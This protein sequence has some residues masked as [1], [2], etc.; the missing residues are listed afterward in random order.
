MKI[1]HNPARNVRII[2]RTAPRQAPD[3]FSIHAN[4]CQNT[5]RTLKRPLQP[6]KFGASQRPVTN[7]TKLHDVE[8]SDDG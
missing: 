2:H 4:P 8:T 7:A 1:C 5:S 3:T 6:P